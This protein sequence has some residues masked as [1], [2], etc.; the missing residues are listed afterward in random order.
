MNRA[1]GDPVR[2]VIAAVFVSLLAAIAPAQS[3]PASQ[4]EVQEVTWVKTWAQAL[5][6]ANEL[7]KP[8]MV[9]FNMD[10]EPACEGIARTHFHDKDLVA[11]SRKFVCVVGSRGEHAHEKTALIPADSPLCHR[12]GSVTCADHAKSEIDARTDVLDSNNVTAPQFVFLTPDRR[13]LSR[14]VYELSPGD[15]LKMMQRALLYFSP[16]NAEKQA[17]VD[18]QLVIDLMKDAA[19]DNA[20][21]RKSAITSL[22]SRDEPEII[23][24]FLAQTSADVDEIK[25][26]EAIKAIS[27]ARNAN[28]LPRLCQLLK[29]RSALIRKESAKALFQMGMSE[30]ADDL[31]EAFG[32][33]SALNTKA[34]HLRTLAVCAGDD[35]RVQDLLAKSLVHPKSVLRAHAAYAVA[36]TFPP[37]SSFKKLRDMAR[38]DTDSG[39]RATALCSATRLAQ[40]FLMPVTPADQARVKSEHKQSVEKDLRPVLRNIAEHDNDAALKEIAQRCLDALE[41]KGVDFEAN[42]DKFF[43]PQSIFEDI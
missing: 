15:L 3:G 33:E 9:H 13:I 36:Y 23:K 32:V 25:R 12:F 28:C 30:P 41:K 22:A 10:N 20:E 35:P 29:D 43:K 16:E 42:L 6:L 24:F 4:P 34:L 37:L 31:R 40:R 2:T 7:K 26:R 38:G 5:K 1:H 18:K 39:V 11:L 27:D 21:R 19:S 8:I 14:R 17:D